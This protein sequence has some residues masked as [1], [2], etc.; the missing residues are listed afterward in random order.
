ME[1]IFK[2]HGFDLEFYEKEKEYVKMLLEYSKVHNITAL[3]DERSA[4]E[5]ILDSVFVLKF[6]DFS[7]IKV[8]DVGSGAG[9]PGIHLAIVL[10]DCEF[11]LY[12]PI[13][14]KSA[15]L[16]LVKAKLRLD[17]VEIKTDRIEKIKDKKYDLITSRA[18]TNTKLLLKLCKGVSH[19]GT[20]Y[21]FYKGSRV[22]DEIEELENYRLWT[23]GDRNYLLLEEQGC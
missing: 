22:K 21:L 3:R 15:F 9:F 4:F 13:A 1:E 6:T 2:K 20:K 5:N 18:V 14:K 12:E 7:K 10:K 16:H 17:N 19:E 23:R 11:D 8:C